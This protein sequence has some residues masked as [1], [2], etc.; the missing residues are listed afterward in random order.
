MLVDGE[1]CPTVQTAVRNFFLMVDVLNS[2]IGSN[3]KVRPGAVVTAVW[4]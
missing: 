3:A 2:L 1:T 4:L